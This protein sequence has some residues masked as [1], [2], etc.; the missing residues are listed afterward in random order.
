LGREP[1]RFELQE[2]SSAIRCSRLA[3]L[4]SPSRLKRRSYSGFE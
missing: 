4:Q 2:A 1:P 3:S